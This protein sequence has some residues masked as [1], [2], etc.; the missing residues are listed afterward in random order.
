MAARRDRSGLLAVGMRR[1]LRFGLWTRVLLRRLLCGPRL[2]LALLLVGGG[3]LLRRLRWP[4]VVVPCGFAP[5]LLRWP[6]LVT[7][8]LGSR[9]E[10][11]LP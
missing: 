7:A 11:W 9:L 8:V 3:G 10:P 5:R 1:R 6:L 4:L 2:A